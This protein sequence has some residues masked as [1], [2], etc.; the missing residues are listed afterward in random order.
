MRRRRPDLNII[1]ANKLF[2][3]YKYTCFV[4]SSFT[5]G[6]FSFKLIWYKKKTGQNWGKDQHVLR[7]RYNSAADTWIMDDRKA[8]SIEKIL[9]SFRQTH[10]R[11]NSRQIWGISF[12]GDGL[13]FV[14]RLLGNNKN[15]TIW[16]YFSLQSPVYWTKLF[17]LNVDWVLLRLISNSL[18]NGLCLF[19]AAAQYIFR[20]GFY[21]Q[22]KMQYT[23]WEDQ[24]DI[25]LCVTWLLGRGNGVA[26]FVGGA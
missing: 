19:A 24:R 16:R 25:V 22:E 11:K 26:R 18:Y 7:Q 1:R 21:P 8:F 3:Q 23:A 2:V 15:I 10:P 9:N 12:S 14:R 6:I 17:I 20:L 4:S 5:H 13:D